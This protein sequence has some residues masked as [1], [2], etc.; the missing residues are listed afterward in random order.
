MNKSE[1]VKVIKESEFASDSKT[2]SADEGF[3]KKEAQDLVDDQAETLSDKIMKLDKPE[4]EW[5]GILNIP[6]VII[7]I[8]S[9]ATYGLCCSEEPLKNIS[10]IKTIK[11]QPIKEWQNKRVSI[12]IRIKK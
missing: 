11:I 12:Q 8:P 2:V 4:W 9:Q 1:L 6:E 5:E 3:S 10:T 7:P